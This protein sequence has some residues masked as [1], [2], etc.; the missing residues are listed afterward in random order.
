MLLVT[1]LSTPRNFRNKPGLLLRFLYIHLIHFVK[2]L[3]K[4]LEA[5]FKH[6]RRMGLM[7]F[8]VLSSVNNDLH[9]YVFGTGVGCEVTYVGSTELNNVPYIS[10]KVTCTISFC[11]KETWMLR[12]KIWMLKFLGA[13]KYLT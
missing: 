11:N 5:N 13:T 1:T 9:I 12:L 8:L 6:L 7:I 3:S 4:H 2:L 10:A